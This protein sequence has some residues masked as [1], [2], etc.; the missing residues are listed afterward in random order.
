MMNRAT[1]ALLSAGLWGAL[2]I[3][4]SNKAINN[5]DSLKTDI[6]AKLYADPVTKGGNVGVDV[7][8]G[9]VTLTGDVPSSDVELQAMK[10]ANGTAGVRSV[11]DQM[12]VNGT[13]AANPMPAN[14]LN[15]GDSSAKPMVA[16]NA[17]APTHSAPPPAA[18]PS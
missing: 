7:K 4:C 16:P 12:K 18:A 15:A 11:S 17:L 9:V 10:I 14:A 3:G 13:M 6:Q 1:M 2:T 5:D 8:D